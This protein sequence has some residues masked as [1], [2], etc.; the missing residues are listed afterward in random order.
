MEIYNSRNK[1]FVKYMMNK[2]LYIYLYY[3][4]KCYLR[5]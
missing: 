2:N 1:K 3:I 4:S 5:A